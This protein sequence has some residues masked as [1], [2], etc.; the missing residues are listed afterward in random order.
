MMGKTRTFSFSLVEVLI[1]VSILSV[2]FVIAAS[3][4]I[5]SIR[6]NEVNQHKILGTRYAEEL[7]EWLRS[8]KEVD[9]KI[10]YSRAPLEPETKS[11]CFNNQLSNWTSI[12][13]GN[14]GTSYTLDDVFR[15]WATLQ[16][17]GDDQMKV[18]VTVQ[19]LEYGNTYSIPINT[20]FSVHE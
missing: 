10:F 17:Y 16:Q 9:W 11:Y 4:T 12:P 3:M 6:N 18:S 20:V 1:F 5:T 13:T 19:W 7:L 8:E 15:R 2:F 14:C